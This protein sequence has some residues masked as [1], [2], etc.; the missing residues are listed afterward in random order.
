MIPD[1]FSQTGLSMERLRAF[2]LI[3]DAGGF[4]KAAGGDISKQPLMS[5]QI[6]ELEGYFSV[7]LLRRSGR[8]VALTEEGKELYR[9][10]RDYFSALGD[11]KNRCSTTPVSLNIGAGDSVIQW[12][13]LPRLALARKALPNVTLRLLNLPTSEIVNKVADGELE[14]GIVRRDASKER[15]KSLNLGRM[16]F[17]LFVAKKSLP[18]GKIEDW[19]EVLKRCPLAV[20]EGGGAFRQELQA[21]TEKAGVTLRVEV[22]C[23]SFPAGARAVQ[24]AGLAAILPVGA[25]HELAEPKFTQ[26]PLPWAKVLARELELIWSPRV[27]D[28]RLMVPQAAEVLGRIWRG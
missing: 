13:I 22:E 28:I 5:R 15:L 8:G 16:D 19:Q 27:A 1:L 21:A 7:E 18:A 9:M 24:S 10:A 17:A 6:K 12:L 4:T 23:S 26:I 14:L 11:F 25:A 2:C 3:A 20:L